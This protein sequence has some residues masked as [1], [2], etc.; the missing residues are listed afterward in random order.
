MKSNSN[1][2]EQKPRLF[3][4]WD[5]IINGGAQENKNKEEGKR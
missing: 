2:T 4:L 3:E 5:A 1:K